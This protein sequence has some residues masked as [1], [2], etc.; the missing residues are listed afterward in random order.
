MIGG[1]HIALVNAGDDVTDMSE[2]FGRAVLRNFKE[3]LFGAVNDLRD[4]PLLRIRHTGHVVAGIDE[5]PQ[6]GF[7]M[8]DPRIVAHIGCRR[9][10]LRQL[11]NILYPRVFVSDAALDERVDQ[12]HG[13]DLAVGGIHLHECFVHQLM[14][15]HI[16]IVRRNGAT[17]GLNAPCGIDED[18]TEHALLCLH[19]ERQT[20]QGISR[21]YPCTVTR[22]VA[23]IS[24]Y[25][26]TGTR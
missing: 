5:A 16:K 6:K 1:I 17:D 22:Q 13:I 21:H 20:A 11:G 9:H 26:F 10:H 8:Y 12:R 24:S 15:F 4:F 23:V 3:F 14:F 7:I 18:R 25:S 19:G 2:F